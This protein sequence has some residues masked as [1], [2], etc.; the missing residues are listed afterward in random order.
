MSKSTRILTATL[1]LAIMLSACGGAD[2][3]SKP[4][5]Q[6][7][8][9][10]DEGP[11]GAMTYGGE[12]IEI[13]CPGDFGIPKRPEG[14]GVDDIRGL[15]LGVPGEI[16]IRY[17][18]CPDG[19]EADSIYM[20]D[21]DIG[22]GRQP[23]GLKIRTSANV[24]VGEHGKRLG[25]VDYMAR[26]PGERLKSTSATWHFVMDGM[27]GKETLFGM[28]LE[29]SFPDG[30]QPTVES[31][32][33]ALKAKYGTPSLEERGRMFWLHLPDGKPIPAFERQLLQTCRWSTDAAGRQLRW[34]PDCGL[35]IAAEVT[36]ATNPLQARQV[37]VAAFDPAKLWSYHAN[38]FEAE[39][40]ALLAAQAGTESKNAKG[41][42]L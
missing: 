3:A 4:A 9:A 18:Q 42:A 39:R 41:A 12:K 11:S 34:G 22:F 20:E 38:R 21:A 13:D 19:E 8:L 36:S 6:R 5:E 33:A 23:L 35:V 25:N 30:S 28:A 40:D 31:Q 27:P 2:S 17:A 37:Q 26:N 24:A 1:P 29:Q 14:S 7:K 15:R 10:A 32:I 16:A